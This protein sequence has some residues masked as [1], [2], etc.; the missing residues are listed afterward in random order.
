MEIQRKNRTRNSLDACTFAKVV[1][2]FI[3]VLYHS[4]IFWTGTWFTR[5]PIIDA[6]HISLFAY[7]LNSFQIYAFMI[8]S[9]YVYYS[10]R[11][12]HN[13]YTDYGV[14]VKTKI[15][16]LIMPY[17]AVA[18]LWIIPWQFIY[19]KVSLSEVIRNFVLAYSPSQIWYLLV[20]FFV[21]VI[22]RLFDTKIVQSSAFTIAFSLGAYI[23]GL[24][25][26]RTVGNLLMLDRVGLYICS[27]CLGFKLRQGS[28]RVIERIPSIV[29]LGLNLCFFI[30]MT[31]CN[32]TS[33]YSKML[34]IVLSFMVNNI[35]ALC[36]FVFLMR[37][38]IKVK[39]RS[40]VYLFFVKRTMP[41]YLL[42]QQII[43]L[44]V[45]WL[46]GVIS[47]EMHVVVNFLFSIGLSTLISSVLLSF[48]WTRLI[49][50]EGQ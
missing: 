39:P 42:H 49:I 24:L 17:C 1:L 45:M 44:P 11:F 9:G 29:L 23:V 6:P 36:M 43:F 21:F 40:S 30:A 16:R 3:V 37:A 26:E 33:V 25:L 32:E 12:E 19:M 10:M 41:I 46:N 35:G 38:A 20:L 7:W 22:V 13:K 47:P 34:K 8:A 14:F 27:F 5:N 31:L 15:K 18:L 2:M 50:G 48:K 28:L 4:C